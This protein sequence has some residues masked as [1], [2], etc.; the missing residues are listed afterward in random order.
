MSFTTPEGYAGVAINNVKRKTSSGSPIVIED[1]LNLSA[2]KIINI[3]A[4]TDAGDVLRR[5]QVPGYV[6]QAWVPTFGANG[7]MTFTGIT[8]LRAEYFEIGAGYIYFNLD[9]LGTIGGTLNNEITFTLPTGFAGNYQN[10]KGGF[11][12]LDFI[13]SCDPWLQSSPTVRVSKPDR[14]NFT[15]G[16][17]LFGFNGIYKRS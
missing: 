9:G 15:S 6:L 7:S 16:S 4:G 13:S 14:S 5:D 12:Q 11:T 2:K 3:A 8:S 1:P 17:L 10:I